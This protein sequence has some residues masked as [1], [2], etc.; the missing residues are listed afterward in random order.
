MRI[1]FRQQGIVQ[2]QCWEATVLKP[3]V[4]CFCNPDF[5][6]AVFRCRAKSL[7]R[8]SQMSWFPG[9]Q[10][11]YLCH[12]RP[13]TCL[14]FDFPVSIL[15]IEVIHFRWPLHVPNGLPVLGS[16]SQ[17]FPFISAVQS[18]WASGDQDTAKTQFSCPYKCVLDFSHDQQSSLWKA[19]AH[20]V[21]SSGNTNSIL[22][23]SCFEER[24]KLRLSPC[25]CAKL[26]AY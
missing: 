4:P 19:P 9:L 24:P 17:S 7:A 1:A 16:H 10:L 26:F 13:T 15:T 23:H 22:S 18:N 11:P 6:G 5:D 21:S 14:P 8:I 3:A 25:M 2:L 12:T 20:E